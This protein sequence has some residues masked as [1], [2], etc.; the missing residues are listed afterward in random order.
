VKDPRGTVDLQVPTEW[1][2]DCYLLPYSRRATRRH[3]KWNHHPEVQD[4][5]LFTPCTPRALVLRNNWASL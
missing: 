4:S 3:T 1:K 5:P 2:C